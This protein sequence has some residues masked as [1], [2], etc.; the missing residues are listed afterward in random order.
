MR[1]LVDRDNL[2]KA[3]YFN[4]IKKDNRSVVLTRSLNY[5]REKIEK[6]GGSKGSSNKK[7]QWGYPNSPSQ[8]EIKMGLEFRPLELFLLSRVLQKTYQECAK[9]Y[10]F[11]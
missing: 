9:G 1:L 3:N 5:Y 8:V 4:D 6:V 10:F 2:S 11:I 7:V